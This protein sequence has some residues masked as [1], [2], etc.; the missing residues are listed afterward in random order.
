M[1]EYN[2]ILVNI[3]HKIRFQEN[4]DQMKKESKVLL[5]TV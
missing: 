4:Q 5:L 1:R 2:I 3:E